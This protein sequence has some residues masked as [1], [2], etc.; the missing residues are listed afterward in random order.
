MADRWRPRMSPAMLIGILI[1]IAAVVLLK[2]VM[3]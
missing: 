1:G 2:L 3:Q